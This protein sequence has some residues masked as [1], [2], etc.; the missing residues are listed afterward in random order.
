[1]ISARATRQAQVAAL[2]FCSG[3]CAL[4]YQTVW[5]R[6][7]RLLFGASTAATA[8]TLAVFM[9]GLGLG[10]LLLGRRAEA[11]PRPL[12]LYGNLEVL[13][14]VLAAAT[15]LLQVVARAAYA[16]TGG[17]QVLGT[18]GATVARLALAALVIGPATFL[19]GATLPAA[20]REV[21]GARDEGRSGV[22]VLIGVNTLGAVL[23]VFLTTFLLLEAL[24]ARDTLN[25][26]AL[27]NLVIGA[28]ARRLARR[29]VPAGEA[30]PVPAEAPQA[31]ARAA[32][33]GFVIA[34]AAV[35]GFAFMIMELVW[36]RMLGPVLGGS[37]YTFGLI[38]GV[39]L[40][41][42]GAGGGA[43]A[44]WGL[45]RAPTVLGLAWTCGLEA[46]VIA[47]P[48]LLGD[49]VALLGAFLRSFAAAG[50][51]AL[52]GAW[53][54]VAAL[55]VF[56]AAL[57][58]GFQFPLLIGLLGRGR[59]GVAREVGVAYAANTAGSILGSV[60]GGFVLV[61]LLS[62]PGTWALA[63]AVL[64]ALALWALALA[65]GEARAGRAPALAGAGLAVVLAL[66]CLLARGPSA[67]WRHSAIGAGRSGV[68]SISTLNQL[69]AWRNSRNRPI[70]WEQD[71]VESSVALSAQDGL[72]FVVNGKIDGNAIGDVGT[73]VMAGLVG[74]ALHPHPRSAFVVGLGTGSTA[75]WLAAVPSIERVDVA[76][77]EPAILAVA[78]ACAEVNLAVLENPRVRV[79]LDDARELLT[80][81]RQRYDVIFSEPSNPYRAGIASLYTAEFYAA[82]KTRLSEDGV[83]LQ[84]L[85]AYEIDAATAR[86]VIVTLRSVFPEVELW[87]TQARD[88]LLVA[89][90][91]AGPIDA[92]LLRRRL[93]EE[94]F[95]KALRVA[96]ATDSLEG[97][98]AH[99]LAGPRLAAELA[100]SFPLEVNRDDDN[101]VEFAFAR[102]VGLTAA[103]PVAQ[104]RA[105]ASALAAER[106]P[107]GAGAF[108]WE[109]WSEETMLAT[110]VLPGAAPQ[111]ARR[112]VEVTLRGPAAAPAYKAQPFEPHTLVEALSLAR[113]LAAAGDEGSL[114][115]AARFAGTHPAEERL[116]HALLRL[117]Q[118]RLREAE[119]AAVE[120][121]AAARA[122]VWVDLRAGL[123]LLLD[124]LPRALRRSPGLGGALQAALAKPLPAW[125]SESA[126]QLALVELATH[127]GRAHLCGPA[128]EALEPDVPWDGPF[129][130]A[131]AECYARTGSPRAAEA[132]RDLA[133]FREAEPAPLVV[134]ADPGK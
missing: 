105:L 38:L 112:R 68:K 93:A 4:V 120:G 30:V 8:A 24:G 35:V 43:Y 83:F 126:R 37:T 134:P 99:R 103:S 75:G 122:Q 1:M 73:Q 48:Y 39:A 58:A 85:Q 82:A 6:Q 52:V 114:A 17:S 2:L 31:A 20:A 50:F 111:A 106:P 127:A 14:G 28:I 9:G 108:D 125:Q 107:I 90:N 81:S 67:A 101:P 87:A 13:V 65:R 49:R 11:H 25:G 44:L 53:A 59:P 18:L 77:I 32:P 89:R 95:R 69:R 22:A 10:G 72:A 45:R 86:S 132:S 84:W 92:D 27:L 47:L 36:Y 71:G 62:A 61:P 3:L 128:F 57:I 102:T 116:I 33:A 63:V 40:L 41:G 74:A 79:H 94:P 118:G 80:T 29:E 64:G 117:R 51:P 91:Q 7:F 42:I 98:L 12:E 115:L 26:A 76:E 34:A 133:R 15:P 104:L 60:A 100:A 96:W 70:L 56:P 119:A 16:A 5:M 55:V 97:F 123:P 113:A 88:L 66:A 23:G 110:G 109:R 21:T 121:L 129:L 46:L 131:R 19:M 124:E 130:Q 78:K 54:V